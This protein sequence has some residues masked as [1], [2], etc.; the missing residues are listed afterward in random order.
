[1][2][3]PHQESGFAFTADAIIICKRLGILSLIRLDEAVNYLVCSQDEATGTFGGRT[4]LY[5]A[6]CLEA[7]SAVGALNLINGS[8]LAQRVVSHHYNA[9]DGGFYSPEG[10]CAIDIWMRGETP[11]NRSNIVCTFLAVRILRELNMLDLIDVDRT[12]SWVAS[13]AGPD[14]GFRPYPGAIPTPQDPTPGG[15][16]TGAWG[17]GLPYTFCA[18]QIL[19]DLGQLENRSMIDP[20]RTASFI[21]SCQTSTG[22]FKIIPTTDPY[23]GAPYDHDAMCMTFYAFR[24]LSLLGAVSTSEEGL[25]QAVTATLNEQRLGYE[26]ALF[27]SFTGLFF[28]SKWLPDYGLFSGRFCVMEGTFYAVE[29]LS[30]AGVLYLL[31]TPT[32]RSAASWTAVVGTAGWSIAALAGIALLRVK[33]TSRKTVILSAIL[34]LTA[35]LIF[36]SNWIELL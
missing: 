7:L 16:I 8:L 1:M 29:I 2:I 26:D 20:E 25:M 23:A 18:V 15:F 31:D 14:G 32:P 5:D 10:L 27:N 22:D 13:C 35:L 34:Y 36:V 4:D 17:T 12:L 19:S 6:W 28:L 30:L 33:K 11:F 24:A 9:S 3:E 21:W